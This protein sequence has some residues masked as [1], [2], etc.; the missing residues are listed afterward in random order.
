[1]KAIAK[2]LV[3]AALVFGTI[4]AASAG[5]VL[6]ETEYP[7]TPVY[8]ATATAT[9]NPEPYVIQS[10]TAVEPNPAYARSFSQKDRA[11]VREQATVA[12]PF[13]PGLNA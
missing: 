12:L 2:I 8:S 13:G 11:E 4:G 1:M 7:G 6:I 5:S 9:M 10:E 3:P